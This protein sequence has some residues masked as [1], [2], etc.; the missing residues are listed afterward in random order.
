M[1]RSR[2]LGRAN[3]IR[4]TRK[5]LLV[6]EGAKSRLQ[7]RLRIEWEDERLMSSR[8][9]EHGGVQATSVQVPTGAKEVEYTSSFGQACSLLSILKF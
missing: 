8:C 7:V 4:R 3:R 6:G 2:S 9:P 5:T 1:G